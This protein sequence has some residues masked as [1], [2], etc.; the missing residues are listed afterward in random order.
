MPSDSCVVVPLSWGEAVILALCGP[1]QDAA[2]LERFPGHP[3]DRDSVQIGIQHPEGAT[4]SHDGNVSGMVPGRQLVDETSGP[5][6]QIPDRLPAVRPYVGV[7]Y[8]LR[9]QPG[10]FGADRGARGSLENT[11]ATLAQP[12]VTIDGQP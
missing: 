10:D 3:L 9:A 7:G 8:P 11:E 12:G 4:V 2:V 6:V 5:L 1:A